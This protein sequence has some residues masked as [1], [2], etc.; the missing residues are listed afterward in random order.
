MNINKLIYGPNVAGQSL[1]D[2]VMAAKHSLAGQGLAKSVC[3]ATTEEVIA[4]KKKHVDYLIQCTHEPNV[5]IPQLAGLLLERSQ[6]FS[7]VSVFK[8]LLTTH[9][10]MNHGNEKFT[11]YLASN[12]CSF[13]LENFTDKTSPQGYD[14]SPYIRRYAKYI[15]EKAVS[16]RLMAFDFCKVKKGKDDGV[17]R[18]MDSEK[19][20]KALPVLQSQVD[21][22]LEFEVT[23]S[24][25]NNPVIFASFM[26]LFKDLIRLL[27]CY[28][29]AIIN[30]LA[31]FFDMNKKQC[32]ESLDMYK[33]FVT[34]MEGVGK[35]FKVAEGVGIEK[36]DIPDLAQAPSTLLDA[37]E[38]HMK[39]L[40]G[41]KKGTL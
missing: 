22:L 33:K 5:S 8:A 30:L 40:E 16:Y 15:N 20:L 29:D 25:L 4:P 10:L 12:N 21:A 2:R 39:S 7:W 9:S 27:A 24:E 28:N 19:L 41:S 13:K 11:Q 6:N 14:M 17:L 34:R 31:K 18:I 36:G 1:V 23:Q 3:K 35:F 37:L 32:K 38:T 26:M